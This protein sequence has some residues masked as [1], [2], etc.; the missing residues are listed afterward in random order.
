MDQFMS[1]LQASPV[2]FY[3]VKN[4]K[5][6]FEEN[7]FTEL[8]AYE[9]WT[10]EGGGKY[11]VTYYDSAIF[12]FVI[13]EGFSK[14]LH[15][16][17]FRMISAH[18]DQPCFRVKP[19]A[20][21]RQDGYR[22]LNVE[23]YGGPIY[24]T[25]LDRP[26]SLAGRVTLA[27]DDPFEPKSVLV[28]LEKPLLVIPNLAIHMN[29]EVNDGVKLNPQV[30][31]LPVGGLVTEIGEEETSLIEDAIAKKLG[32][33]KEEILDYDLFTYVMDPP[34]KVGVHEE[35]LSASRLDDLVMVH[36]AASALVEAVPKTGINVFLGF[37]HE[38][39]GSQTPQGAG[40]ATVMIALEKLTESLGYSRTEFLDQMAKSFLISGDVAHAI[41]PNHP[42]RHDPLLRTQLGGGP[43][44]K[45]A[46][47]QSYMTQ[48]CDY[49]VYEQICRKAGV[50]VQK[51][52][53]RSDQ[54][55]GSTLGPVV[56]AQMPCRIMD[57]G[58]PIL[59]MHSARELM[60]VKDYD[61]T[62]RSFVEYY[63]A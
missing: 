12:A 23:V 20:E 11:F 2:C 53:N 3:A 60:A 31:L 58:I 6:M 54:R 24:S 46:A 33:K 57:M 62:K 4:L 30:D 32:I 59:S 35:L 34:V 21:M 55:G 37:D 10:V 18:T 43:V 28:D 22:K 51:F 40:S 50:P 38:E 16:P 56:A 36:T 44:I 27:S 9:P 42:E 47:R 61:Y 45:M 39:I 5:A 1:F 14:C 29:R 8:Q 17:L 7:G 25:W 49:A 26:L 13:P 48:S 19:Q 41:H 52:T 15:G 63:N